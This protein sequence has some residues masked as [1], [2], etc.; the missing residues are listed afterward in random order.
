MTCSGTLAARPSVKRARDSPSVHSTSVCWR[1][2]PSCLTRVGEQPTLRELWQ[3]TKQ[4]RNERGD[5]RYG[6]KIEGND[7]FLH[8]GI[9]L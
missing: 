6:P 5:H 2:L 7:G 4:Q 1:Y 8:N 9:E 3:E